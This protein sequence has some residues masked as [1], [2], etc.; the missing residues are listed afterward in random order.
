M[1]S[2]FCGLLF[3]LLLLGSVVEAAPKKGGGHGGKKHYP[4]QSRVYDFSITWEEHA[5]DGYS[6]HMLLVNGES[7]GPTLVADQDDWIYVNVHNYSPYN[8]TLHFHGIEMLGTPWSDGVPGVTQQPIE[9]D[10]SFTY[11]FKATQYGSYWYHAHFRGQIEDGFYGPIVIHPRRGDPD[12]F[13]LISED[14]NV[15]RAMKEAERNVVPLVIADFTHLTSDAKWDMT[16]A[17]GFEDSCYDSILFN[18]KGSVSCLP[19]DEITSFLND[20]QKGLLAIVPGA[21]VSDKACL[22]PSVLIALGGGQ[23]NESALLP[24]VFSGCEE[25]Q[26]SVEV[27]EPSCEDDEFIAIDIVGAINFGTGVVSIDEHDMWVY[28]VD[29]S[30]IEP[31]KVQ[32]IVVTNGDRYSVLVKLDKAGDFKIRFNGVTPLQMLGGHAI[33]SVPGASVSEEES[34]PY[35]NYVGVPLTPDVIFFNPNIA[36]PY[37]PDPI[38]QTADALFLLNMH[39]DGASYLWALNSSRLMPIDLDAGEPTL[40]KP[41]FSED[42]NVTL[43]TK[44]NTWVDLVFFASVFPQ[45]PHPIHK[46]GT[47]MYQI[48]AGTGP[49]KWKSVDEAIQEIPDQFNLVNPPRRDAFASLAA[50]TDVT[51]VVVRYHASNPGAWL[52][53]CHINNHM[54]GGMMMVIQDGVDEWPEIPE[55]YQNGRHGGGPQW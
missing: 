7:P 2:S 48:G 14:I 42:N 35:V 54:L 5:P 4:G 50:D 28:A 26:G 13:H 40:F 6:R 38:S 51:W 1:I 3:S 41:D 32:A 37:P 12:P 20:Q 10:A 17:T 52:L 25:T 55:N 8:T 45:P 30:Y 39:F 21:S 27:I 43:S 9:P 15:R 29:G 31:Q 11:K 47:K 19:E 49:F 23:G 24:G 16:L 18:G 34:V 44:Y 36:F 53:H 22:P 46:H 33:L